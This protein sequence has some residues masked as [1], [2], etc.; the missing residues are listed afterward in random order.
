MT[1]KPWTNAAKIPS[2]PSAAELTAPVN[3]AMM[4]CSHVLN[5]TPCGLV[6]SSPNDVMACFGACQSQI[7]LVVGMLVEKAAVE[8]ASSIPKEGEA[9]ECAL[10]FPPEAAVDAKELGRLCDARCVELV[11]QAP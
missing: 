11:A 5:L 8:C 9:R 4:L 10:H 2:P 7:E 3:A 1:E 6:T